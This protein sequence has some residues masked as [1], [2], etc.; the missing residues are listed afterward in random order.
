M[1]EWQAAM[2]ALILVDE[3]RADDAGADRRHE[4]IEPRET[5]GGNT[6]QGRQEI[7]GRQIVN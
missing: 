7:S 1:C 5:A 2:E 3:R 6:T 4:G